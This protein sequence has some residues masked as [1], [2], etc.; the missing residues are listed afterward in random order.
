M[1]PTP[2]RASGDVERLERKMFHIRRLL[3]LAL[4]NFQQF[5]RSDAKVKRYAVPGASARQPQAVLCSS[6]AVIMNAGAPH[7]RPSGVCRRGCIRRK[8]F[9][10][11][12][13]RRIVAAAWRP[14]RNQAFASWGASSG[15]DPTFGE[16]LPQVRTRR[17]RLPD[18]EGGFFKNETLRSGEGRIFVVSRRNRRLGG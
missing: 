1:R 13:A 9:Q 6:S 11:F 8:A 17:F 4:A 14:R 15:V 2:T 5:A 16:G 7:I 10:R 3:C 18:P 12:P